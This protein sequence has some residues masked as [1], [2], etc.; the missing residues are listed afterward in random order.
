MS[1]NNIKIEDSKKNRIY[2]KFK[3]DKNNNNINDKKNY[4]EVE[5]LQQKV[6][7]SMERLKIVSQK[8]KEFEKE[9]YDYI[10]EEIHNEFLVYLNKIKQK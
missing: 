3:E 5:E 10:Q 2:S 9:I 4:S 8:T 7:K 6:N 1:R